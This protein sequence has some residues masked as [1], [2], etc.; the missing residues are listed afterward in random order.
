MKNISDN[1]VALIYLK[2]KLHKWKN[3]S[4]FLLLLCLMLL[5]RVLLGEVTI[6]GAG[7]NYIAN[8]KI[9]GII[10][11]DS[12]RSEILEKIALDNNVKAVIININSPGGGIVGSE[13]LYSEIRAISQIKP[14][15]VLMGSIA[16]SGGYM[17]AIGADHIIAHNGTL[18]GS[19]GTLSQSAEIT[20]LASKIGVKLQTYKSSPFKAM[21]SF[22]EKSNPEIDETI[23]SSIMDSYKF[24]S[25]LVYE[26][27]KDRLDKNNLKSI[28]DGRVFTGRQALKL[29]LIDEIGSKGNA[30]LYLKNFHK[31]DIEKT[32]LKELSLQKNESRF[33]THFLNMVPFYNQLNSLVT[34]N[35]QIMAIVK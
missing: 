16:A 28:M 7:G 10:F 25:D 24:F 29:G 3:I 4:F 21:P 2:N 30:L 20:E 13:V 18:T 6:T 12:Y 26:R 9:E 17:S 33:V 1:L 35:K 14:T 15:V 8:I 22:F 31:I 27:R 5:I 23:K 34:S 32:P 19:I 11:E